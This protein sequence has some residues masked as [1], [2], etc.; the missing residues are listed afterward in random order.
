MRKLV[1]AVLIITAVAGIT[2]DIT[3][4]RQIEQVIPVSDC[5]LNNAHCIQTLL[6][7]VFSVTS[8][9]TLSGFFTIIVLAFVKL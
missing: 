8:G 6:W 3:I 5:Y 9:L 4:N 1:V 2:I 7:G